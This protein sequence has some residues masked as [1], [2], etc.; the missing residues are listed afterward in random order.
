[1]IAAALTAEA[2]EDVVLFGRWLAVRNGHAQCRTGT[3]LRW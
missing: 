3:R 2:D 1:M